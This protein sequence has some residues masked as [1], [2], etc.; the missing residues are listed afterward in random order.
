[1]VRKIIHI[2][3]DAFY[4]SI[5]QRD[6]PHLRGKPIIVGG[7]PHSRGVVATASYEARKFGIHSAMPSIQAYR[8][9]PEAIFVKPRFEIYKQVSERIHIIFRQ[10]T[11]LIEPLALD[12]AYLDVTVNKIKESSATLLARR[13]QSQIAAEV[14]LTA[15]A[16]ASF[17]KFLAKL[18][19]GW[20]K[21]GG[22][23][24]ITPKEAQAFVDELPIGRFYGI[25]KATE[26]KM[27]VLGILKGIDLKNYALDHLIHYFG[28][29]G[30][31]LH[32]LAN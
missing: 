2:D 11:D 26:K 18:A 13:I 10:Y 21:P 15:S 25:G 29:M 22:L 1:M 6:N 12:E 32:Q 9:C 7:N 16:G 19:S 3:M 27:L 4:A 8:K 14:G 30:F 23:T 5:E 28:K 20:K 31:F 17:N 24:V